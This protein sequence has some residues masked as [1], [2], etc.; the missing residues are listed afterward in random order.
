MV[1]ASS[2]ALLFVPLIYCLLEELSDWIRARRG[3]EETSA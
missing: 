3:H 2:L 1:L